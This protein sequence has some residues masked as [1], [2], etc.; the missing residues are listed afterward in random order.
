MA[1][2][3][4]PFPLDP[5]LVLVGGLY[6][7]QG[8]VAGFAVTALPNHHAALGA[9][10]QAVGAHVAA[11]GLPWVVQPLWGP[12]VDRFGGFAMGRRRFWIIAAFLGS[13]LSLSGLLLL[14]ADAA[15]PAI[16]AVF[17]LQGSFAALADTATDGLVIDRV[18][19]GRLGTATAAGRVGFVGGGAVSA[20]FFAWMLPAHGLQAC[21][22]LLLAAGAAIFLLPLLQ[23][24]AAGDAW[25][26]LRRAP[27][28]AAGGGFRDLLRRLAGSLASR[29]TLGLLAACFAIDATGALFGLPLGVALIQQHGWSAEHLSRFQAVTALLTGTVGTLLVGG[30]VDRIGTARA[31]TI[32]LAACGLAYAVSGLGLLLPGPGWAPSIGPLVL[33][34]TSVVP[35]LLFVSLAPAV[36]RASRGPVAATQFALFMAALNAGSV[37][38][39]AVAGAVAGLAGLPVIG[40]AAGALFAGLAILIRRGR[41]LGRD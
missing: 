19:P 31:L 38:G 27:S 32:L 1:D 40:I 41:L 18:P 8:L 25:L 33:G 28:P 15:L 17:L 5:R 24:E 14:P 35:A 11:V 13:L 22:L 2:R 4:P 6:G 21:V 34:L 23:R 16:S 9:S 29:A 30:W 12:V 37:S 3:P 39:S 20:A 26:S 10:A 36:M 7:W